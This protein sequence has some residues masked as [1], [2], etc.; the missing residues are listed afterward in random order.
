MKDNME[1]R[2]PLQVD[3]SRKLLTIIAAAAILSIYFTFVSY[4][5]VLYS[6]SY[7]RWD[8]AKYLVATLLSGNKTAI[9]SW[10]SITPQFFMAVC[11]ALTGAY[12]FYTLVQA[13]FFFLSSFLVIDRFTSQCKLATCILFCLCPL[14]YG[15]SV[16]HESSVGCV[17]GLNFA[18]LL[19]CS[20]SLHQYST[21]SRSHKICYWAQ[22][23][24]S[25]YLI[26]KTPF[27]SYRFFLFALE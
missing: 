1:A 21:W 3:G 4:P 22:L 18:L 16:Y 15:F 12:G 19:T 9:T 5:G 6:D 23:V 25:F 8:T 7:G 13:F 11:Y 14:F 20:E 10:L 27:R 17:I 26:A 24:F 2:T